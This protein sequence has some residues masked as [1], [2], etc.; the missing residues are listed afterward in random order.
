MKTLEA[1]GSSDDTFGVYA[2]RHDKGARLYGEDHDDYS[3][4]TVRSF[5]VNAGPDGRVLV[6]GVYGKCPDGTWAIGLSPVEEG[7][8]WPT[9][10][11]PRWSVDGYTPVMTLEVPDHATVR[12]ASVDG[13]VRR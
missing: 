6:V 9:W 11:Q 2:V 4:S 12:L 8:P 1:R 5:E 13:A 3:R 7:D 10:A